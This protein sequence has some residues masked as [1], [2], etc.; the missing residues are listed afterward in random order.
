MEKI[1]LKRITAVVIDGRRPD[2]EIYN[3]YSLIINYMNKYIEFGAIKLFL[4]E[5]P[6]IPGTEFYQVKRMG[7]ADYSKFCIL[8]LSDFIDTDFCLIFQDDG[9][10]LNPHLW[11]EKFYDYD[12]IG[13]P[14]PLYMGWP[15]EGEQVGNGGFS[16]RSKSLLELTKTF[17]DHVTQ[18]EDTFIISAKRDKILK[19]GLK[20]APLEIAKKF[21]VENQIDQDHSMNTCFGFHGKNKKEEAI[22]IIREMI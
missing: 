13:S 9:F 15:V 6:N 11:D 22:N 19:A 12:Y 3:N 8:E 4:C 18:N 1:N 21:S 17:T 7:I 16:L 14:W 5:N 20:I 2:E 10:V